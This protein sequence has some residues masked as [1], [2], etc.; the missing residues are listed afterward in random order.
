MTEKGVPVGFGKNSCMRVGQETLAISE[1]M[2]QDLN[3]IINEQEAE[4]DTI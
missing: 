3:G 4:L 1:V 2:S